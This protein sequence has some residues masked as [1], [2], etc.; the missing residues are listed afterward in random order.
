MFQ[1]P[2]IWKF[3]RA[4]GQKRILQHG[5][6]VQIQA[7]EYREK[8]NK[9]YESL[10]MRLVSLISKKQEIEIKP[11]M[12]LRNQESESI[13]FRAKYTVKEDNMFRSGATAQSLILWSL[14]LV[15]LKHG[16]RSH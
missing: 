15:S 9:A 5:E 11:L 8:Q 12:F 16:F 2:P 1:G 7:V 13:A 14:K 10:N 6:L 4:L 3:V